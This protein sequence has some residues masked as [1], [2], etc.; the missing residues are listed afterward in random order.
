MRNLVSVLVLAVASAIPACR[1]LEWRH[2]GRRPCD[3]PT[4]PGTHE[5][6]EWRYT[7]DGDPASD[8]ESL[9]LNG[10]LFRDGQEVFGRI[11]EVTETPLGTFVY[12]GKRHQVSHWNC[13]WLNTCT[14]NDPVFDQEGRIRAIYQETFDLWKKRNRDEKRDGPR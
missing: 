12:F 3:F 5:A 10:R 1:F 14:Y 7:L 9:V 11:G 13:G 6:G 4:R 8:S 2:V